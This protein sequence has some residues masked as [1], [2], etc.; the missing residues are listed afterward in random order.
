MYYFSIVFFFGSNIFVSFFGSNHFVFFIVKIISF[1]VFFVS[2]FVSNCFAQRMEG[3]LYRDC[4]VVMFPLSFFLFLN[5]SF[6]YFYLLFK[7][8]NGSFKNFKNDETSC[9]ACTR[10]IIVVKRR[11]KNLERRFVVFEPFLAEKNCG[12]LNELKFVSTINK[13]C[14]LCFVFQQ[15]NIMKL[16]K[17]KI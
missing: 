3:A 12:I 17:R 9:L 2:F 14:F 10:T 15:N 8:L 6:F 5:F 4:L 16:N 1:S 13:E 11:G 7:C